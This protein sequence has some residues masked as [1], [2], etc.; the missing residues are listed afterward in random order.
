MSEP[1]ANLLDYLCTHADPYPWDVVSPH[2]QDFLDQLNQASWAEDEQEFADR[3]KRFFAQFDRLFP[4]ASVLVQLQRH[5]EDKIPTSY[6]QRMIGTVQKV[7]HNQKSTSDQLL[8][9]ISDL[10]PQWSPEDLTLLARPYCTA[11]RQ[12]TPQTQLPEK[13]TQPWD[14]LSPIEQAKYTVAIAYFV[15][16]QLNSEA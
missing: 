14:R 4:S 3:S 16:Q 12:G 2:N 15:Q 13:C 7:A 8:Q 11:L 10:L 6:L 5:F 9:A 1:L